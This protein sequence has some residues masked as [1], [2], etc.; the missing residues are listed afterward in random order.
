M[1]TYILPV[2]YYLFFK[3]SKFNHIENHAKIKCINLGIL[4]PCQIE[5]QY[6]TLEMPNIVNV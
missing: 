1:Y 4:F 6:D 5:N 2:I 3:F